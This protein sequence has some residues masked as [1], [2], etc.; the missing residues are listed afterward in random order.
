MKTGFS[1][2]KLNT[3]PRIITLDVKPSAQINHAQVLSGSSTLMSFNAAKTQ[4]LSAWTRTEQ[5]V[6][7]GV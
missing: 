6:A 5:A 2:P 1:T 4:P 3:S 7:G